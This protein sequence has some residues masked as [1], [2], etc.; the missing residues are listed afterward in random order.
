MVKQIIECD[1]PKCDS[2]T[3]DGKSRKGWVS[4]LKNGANL[5]VVLSRPGSTTKGNHFCSAT[6]L[7]EWMSTKYVEEMQA[8][9]EALDQEP[10]K[11]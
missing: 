4:G 3:N 9:A 6:C 10:S 11:Q 5:T 8:N 2:H 1:A 7:S